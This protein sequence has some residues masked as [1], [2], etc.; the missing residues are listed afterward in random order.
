MTFH[1]DNYI[2]PIAQQ[3]SSSM[4]DPE[5]LYGHLGAAPTFTMANTELNGYHSGVVHSTNPLGLTAN[6]HEVNRDSDPLPTQTMEGYFFNKSVVHPVSD[7]VVRSLLI[8][9]RLIFL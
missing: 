7:S 9:D 3:Q 1:P 5:K 2:S 8:I 4:F 6:V